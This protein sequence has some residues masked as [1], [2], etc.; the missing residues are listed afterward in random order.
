M[1]L[2]VLALGW[3]AGLLLAA[4]LPT[5]APVWLPILAVAV[6]GAVLL[7]NR[8]RW[9]AVAIVALALG[10]LR[11]TAYPTTDDLGQWRGQGGL[12]LEGIVSTAPVLSDSALLIR[13]DVDTVKKNGE[14]I[15]A[16]GT[17][18]VNAPVTAAAQAGDRVRATGMLEAPGWY[19]DLDYGAYLARTGIHSLL[20]DA[21]IEVLNSP[22]TPTLAGLLGEARV[23]LV[24]GVLRSIPPPQS[25]LLVAML[26]GDESGIA[27]E[28]EAAF[29]T[30]GTA[31]LIA[32]SGFN[33]I[34]VSSAVQAILLRLRVR[35]GWAAAIAVIVI[36][37][38]TL[39]VGASPAIL[40]AAFMSALLVIGQSLRR[41]TF[42]ASSLAFA[43]IA[44]TLLN[45]LALWDIGFQLS[46]LAAFGIALF[47]VPITHA[48]DRLA[49]RWLPTPL[50]GPM[51]G[52]VT[53]ALGTSLAAQFTVLPLIALVFGRVS[54]VSPIVNLLVA[55]A[56]A[57]L[58]LSGAV[59]ALLSVPSFAPPVVLAPPYL[60]IS[61]TIAVVE[62][63]ARVPLAEFVFYPGPGAV[64]LFYVGLLGGGLLMA[65]HPDAVGRWS[66]RLRSRPLAVT[67]MLAALGILVLTGARL[68][69]TA[70]HH[71][72]VWALDMDGDSAILIQ[73]PG[74][75]HILVDGGS[76]PARLLTAIGERLPFDD[77][78]LELWVL[79]QPSLN[80]V[81]SAARLLDQ[82]QVDTVLTNGQSVLDSGLEEVLARP[83][84]VVPLVAGQ[85]V[86]LSDGVT[87]E[88]LHP[89]ATPAETGSLPDQAL[90][91]RVT[92]GEVSFLL[93]GDLSAAGQADLLDAGLAQQATVVQLPGG[94]AENTV[95]EEFLQ[96]VQ[97]QAAI[98]QSRGE[99]P[100]EPAPD[101]LAL[102]GAL[103]VYN[104]RS[105]DIHFSTDGSRLWVEQS[106]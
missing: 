18:L 58:L 90:V 106:P 91:L 81:Q 75:A 84:N 1:R 29:A 34:V 16:S 92:H 6:L 105:G 10:G 100:N 2:V 64:T 14:R 78:A 74:G 49:R 3:T 99:D 25:G 102:L 79:T 69:T 27:P 65:A 39:L 7:W 54:L 93:T 76:H 71:L 40:R 68:L 43:L 57:P 95:V 33:M 41:R 86:T 30:T 63:A 73:T 94:G 96:A 46:M 66:R 101:T 50:V 87:L 31:H 19:G 45:P 17:V 61:F 88:V 23:A 15:P 35:R 36:L 24:S 42:I 103:P 12:T 55:P 51:E 52:F 80:R 28:L 13:L 53:P 20:R 4:G 5:S 44:L 8:A 21:S 77:R 60:L 83:G 59:G 89:S 56:Q 70:D 22:S 38:Y 98:L 85:E 26:L 48:G 11:F 82:Y 67:V 62:A 72:H 97:P 32:I 9:P 37:G 47:A 104:S